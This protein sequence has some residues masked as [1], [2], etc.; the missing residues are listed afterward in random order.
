MARRY[1]EHLV[2]RTGELHIVV[3]QLQ[4]IGAYIEDSDRDFWRT[5]ADLY[6]LATVQ[7]L[8]DGRDVRMGMKHYVVTMQAFFMVDRDAFFLHYP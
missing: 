8:L 1:M 3:A 6:V 5:E 2:F 4:S 7:Q